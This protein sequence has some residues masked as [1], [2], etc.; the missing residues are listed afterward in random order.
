MADD[1]KVPAGRAYCF[2]VK[3]RKGEFTPQFKGTMVLTRDYAAGETIKLAVWQQTTKNG[4]PWIKLAE[5]TDAWKNADQRPTQ[6]PREV[7]N[8]D[9]NEV[10][11]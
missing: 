8:I 4:A 9:E 1:F 5:E 2:L 3:D 11:F 10:P 6:Y 7:R